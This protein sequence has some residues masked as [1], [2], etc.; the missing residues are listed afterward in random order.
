MQK[1][2][3]LFNTI[4]GKH[5]FSGA[6]PVVIIDE[7]DRL[8]NEETKRRLTDLVKALS[9]GGAK[10]QLIICGIATSLNEILELHGSSPRYL[11]QVEVKPLSLGGMLQI[12]ADVESKFEI[13]FTKGQRYRIVQIADGYAHFT[14]LMLKDILMEGHNRS[15][16]G[17]AV[18]QNLLKTGIGN[19]V[20]QAE[21]YLVDAYERAT[22]RGTNV[23]IEI[24]WSVASGPHLERQFKAIRDDYYAIM[25]ARKGRPPADEQKI[26]NSLNAM[27]TESCGTILS[28]RTAG[29]YSFTDPLERSYV[30]LVAESQGIDLGEYNFVE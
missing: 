24:L 15:F 21:V 27:C 19:S 11:H 25:E 17:G 20:R 14:H 28:R 4:L 8:R 22:L 1:A 23:N 9:V 2:V 16:R 7:F 6:F 5:Q 12:I 3:D 26:R 30:R 13:K 29:W 18:G 10:V